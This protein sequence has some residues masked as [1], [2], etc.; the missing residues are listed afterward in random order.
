MITSAQKNWYNNFHF[1]SLP[2]ELWERSQWR[3]VPSVW[4][5]LYK[6]VVISKAYIWISQNDHFYINKRYIKGVLFKGFPLDPWSIPASCLSF[7]SSHHPTPFPVYIRRHIVY[8]R[9]YSMK[10]IHGQIKQVSGTTKNKRVVVFERLFGF[11]ASFTLRGPCAK[12][13]PKN[14]REDEQW[15]WPEWVGQWLEWIGLWVWGR[16]LGV[17]L[18]FK[19]IFGPYTGPFYRTRAWK[20]RKALITPGLRGTLSHRNTACQWSRGR[21]PSERVHGHHRAIHRHPPV[22]FH[23]L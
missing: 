22:L 16:L 5:A 3:I 14:I 23:G 9:A 11:I 7:P 2:L 4:K 18:F 8:A 6:N 10:Q 21:A 19:S 20:Y 17:W 12:V 1:E 15:L 13:Q